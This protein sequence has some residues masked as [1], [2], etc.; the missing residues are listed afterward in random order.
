M[1]HIKGDVSAAGQGNTGAV[2]GKNPTME[3]PE[4]RSVQD[5]PAPD[6]RVSLIFPLRFYSVIGVADH[7]IHGRHGKESINR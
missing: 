2:I 4:S 7:G 5:F 1:I 3:K 6:S